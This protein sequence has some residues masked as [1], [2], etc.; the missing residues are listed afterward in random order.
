M[1]GLTN[2][3]V[4][5]FGHSLGGYV[6]LAMVEQKPERFSSFG[7]FHSTALADSLEK[8][9]SRSKTIEFVNRNGALAFTSNF[10]PP[11]F[12]NPDHE[13]VSFVK[14]IA[15]Q[16]DQK[17]VVSY[18]E[19]MRERPDRTKVLQSFEGPILFLAG[20][21]DAVIPLESLKTQ[22]V[23]TKSGVLKV[24]E[25]IGHMGMFEATKESLECLASFLR[26][27]D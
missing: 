19:A 8:K 5:V 15:I 20:S 3:K 25:G 4:S 22:V 11:L 26:G 13:A 21:M 17:T 16:T 12:A 10:I 24:F 23:M 14:K 9:E 7:L 2:E 6:T 18:L 1:Q 27:H